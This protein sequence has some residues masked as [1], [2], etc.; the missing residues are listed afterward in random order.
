MNK[1]ELLTEKL[2][3]V[4]L[5]LGEDTER[6][7]LQETPLRWAKALQEYT[8]GTEIDPNSYVKLFPVDD[9]RGPIDIK[10]IPFW[11]T[12]EHHLAPFW[13]TV[14]ISY[15][16]DEHI[17]GL[18]KFVRIVNAFTKRLQT[19]E[20]ITSDIGLFLSECELAPKHIQVRVDAQHTC[21]CARGA[22]AQ[23]VK[24]T[25]RYN[26]AGPLYLT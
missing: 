1:N 5:L 22:R 21:I 13:G 26:R 12:C 20:R 10:D 8:A 9:Y 3:D 2:N 14:D 17:L 18:S 25:T 4:L 6:P 19:Q 16:P 15:I 7:G 11:S 24:T 23:G